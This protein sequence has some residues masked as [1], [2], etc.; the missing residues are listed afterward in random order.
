MH[1]SNP[2]KLSLREA[3]FKGDMGVPLDIKKR[4]CHVTLFLA[5]TEAIIAHV[6]LNFK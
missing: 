4:D 6:Q 2:K 5:M 3:F 1:E